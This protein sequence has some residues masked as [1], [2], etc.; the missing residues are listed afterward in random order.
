MKQYT[1]IITKDGQFI[2]KLHVKTATEATRIKEMLARTSG[3][4]LRVEIQTEERR[5]A[6]KEISVPCRTDSARVAYD[7]P[8]A[9]ELLSTHPD[10]IYQLIRE[11]KITAFHLHGG[12]RD[13][14]IWREELEKYCR[15][16]TEAAREQAA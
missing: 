2:D 9:A 15:E 7:V 12:K 4:A 8:Q 13:T 10:T 1:I 5:T 14:R 6:P 11:G 16:A 3:P